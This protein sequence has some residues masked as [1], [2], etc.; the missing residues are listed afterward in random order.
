MAHTGLPELDDEVSGS[1]PEEHC[2]DALGIA[3]VKARVEDMFMFEG[4]EV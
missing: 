4:G 3:A 1:S 2:E